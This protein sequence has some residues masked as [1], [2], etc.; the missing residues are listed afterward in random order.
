MK[1][2]SAIGRRAFATLLLATAALA[3]PELSLAPQNSTGVYRPG[4]PVGWKLTAGATP[5]KEAA[6]VLKRGGATPV[7]QGSVS[8]NDGKAALTAAL[9]EP[10]AILAEVPRKQP[11]GSKSRRSAGR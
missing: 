8:F 9:Q 6:Y 3:A 2:T 10:G 7:G 5:I 4:E 1:S 11:T